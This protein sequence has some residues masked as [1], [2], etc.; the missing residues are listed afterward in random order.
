MAQKKAER[1]DVHGGIS[2]A[3]RAEWFDVVPLFAELDGRLNMLCTSE[4][5]L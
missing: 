4:E 1:D 2:H 5:G 3:C